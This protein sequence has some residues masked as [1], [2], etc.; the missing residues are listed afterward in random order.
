MSPA[1]AV[2][3]E[4]GALRAV[5]VDHVAIAVVEPERSV[6]FYG[7]I[8][9]RD[10]HQAPNQKDRYFLGLGGKRY[11]AIAK[12]GGTPAGTVDHICIGV[13]DDRAAV[14]AA[15]DAAGIKWKAGSADLQDVYVQDPDGTRIQ[16]AKS[17]ERSA[18]NDVLRHPLVAG[19]GGEAVLRPVGIDHVSVMV[20]DLERSAAF[21]KK[22][23]GVETQRREDRLFFK[24]GSG[25]VV[26]RRAPK[27][28]RLGI[29]HFC[30][31]VAKVD[32]GIVAGRLKALGSELKR[33]NETDPPYFT[34]ADGVQVQVTLAK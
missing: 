4:S 6:K 2:R 20:S 14:E 32:F 27:G 28:E 19:V 3:G 18:A 10:V 15:L 30:V 24:A 29:D 25:S 34:D 16:I 22:L 7:P 26:V 11:M 9:G 8:L 33:W 17:G 21:Y 5:G 23:F 31:A 1:A 13:E 12:A